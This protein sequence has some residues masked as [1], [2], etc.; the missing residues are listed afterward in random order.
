MIRLLT[1]RFCCICLVRYTI[2][3]VNMATCRCEKASVLWKRWRIVEPC[4]VQA[5]ASPPAHWN[6]A[7][8]YGTLSQNPTRSY[9]T[10]KN[11]NNNQPHHLNFR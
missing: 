4:P 2:R 8:T 9:D 7:Y 5:R 10:K 1:F 6:S 3:S 11:T